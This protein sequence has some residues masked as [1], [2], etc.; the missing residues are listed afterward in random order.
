MATKYWVNNGGSWGD[1]SHWDD[2]S[3]GGGGALVPTIDDDVAFDSNSFTLSDQVVTTVSG[4]CY[5]KS[6]T[7][8]NCLNNPTLYLKYSL[9]IAGNFTLIEDMSVQLEGYNRLVYIQSGTCN[10]TSAGHTLN[11]SL[12]EYGTESTSP[13]LNLLDDLNFSNLSIYSGVF[14]TNDY[15]ITGGEYSSF[16]IGNN[17]YVD[18]LEIYLGSSTIITEDFYNGSIEGEVFDAG[19]SS[20]KCYKSF[21]DGA[22]TGSSSEY[23]NIIFNVSTYDDDNELSFFGSITCNNFTI[24]PGFSDAEFGA[25]WPEDDPIGPAIYAESITMNGSSSQQLLLS[26]DWEETPV[27]FNQ[28]AGVVNVYYIQLFDTIAQGGAVFY[29]LFINGNLDG[30]L[31]W[32]DIYPGNNIGWIWELPLYYGKGSYNEGYKIAYAPGM[33]GGTP[34]WDIDKTKGKVY[35]ITDTHT[36]CGYWYKIEDV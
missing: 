28:E 13:I 29:S 31:A 32:G 34:V 24:N 36:P 19:T 22:A 20:I 35:P 3:G 9:Y 16:S 5:A 25:V 21:E 26:S 8:N 6:L 15:S 33:S 7:F 10:L 17:W 12:S 1:T 4:G 18:Q 14:N 23:Y 30:G 11:I 27:V 2:E